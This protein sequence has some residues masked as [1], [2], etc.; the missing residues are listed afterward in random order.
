[1]RR[2]LPSLKGRA[3]IAALE[4]AG[5]YVH[6]TKGSHHVLRHPAK[7]GVRVVVAAHARDLPTGTL[8]NIIKQADF[9]V[10][11]FLDLL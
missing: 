7:P 1:M 3:V 9:S 4:R 11:E 8:R 5:F 6:H 2:R 10:P